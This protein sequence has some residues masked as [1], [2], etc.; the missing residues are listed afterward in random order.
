M[1]TTEASRS[2][3]TIVTCTHH[4]V[5]ESPSGPT[6][7]GTCRKCGTQHEFANDHDSIPKIDLRDTQPMLNGD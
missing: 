4:W 7:H 1:H 3:D 6:S 5:I 2:K